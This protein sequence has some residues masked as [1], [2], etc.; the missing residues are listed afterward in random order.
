MFQ[1][2]IGAE[3]LFVTAAPVALGIP[4]WDLDVSCRSLILGGM[5]SNMQNY[6]MRTKSASRTIPHRIRPLPPA[7]FL[8]LSRDSLEGL[9]FLPTTSYSS[10]SG[11]RL[12]VSVGGKSFSRRLCE[13]KA[14]NDL[15]E[16]QGIAS[17]SCIWRFVASSGKGSITCQRSPIARLRWEPERASLLWAGRSKIEWMNE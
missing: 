15:T 17:R 9:Y 4:W 13:N 11:R 6:I 3:R 12:K 5:H 7:P 10:Y 2:S 16:K 14:G 8:M 1:T